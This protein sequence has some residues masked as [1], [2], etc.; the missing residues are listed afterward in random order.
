[1]NDERTLVYVVGIVAIVAIVALVLLLRG[2]FKATGLG[3]TLEVDSAKD[4][5]KQEKNRH[6]E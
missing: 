1:M 4:A 2:R 6:G 3:G 5:V